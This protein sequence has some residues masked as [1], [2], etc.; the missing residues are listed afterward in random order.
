MEYEGK[1]I[2]VLGLGIEG[3]DVVGFLLGRGAKITLFDRKEEG[4]IDFTGIEK[5]KL[6]IVTGENYLSG[7]LLG[8]DLIVRSPGVYRFNTE[9]VAAEK[10]GVPITSSIKIFFDECPGKIIGVTGTKGK[11]TTSTLIHDILKSDGRDVYLS[12]NI[13]KPYLELLPKLTKDS[14]VVMEM[15][16]FQLIDADVSPHIAVVLNITEDHMDWHVDREE[17]LNAK[18]NIARFQ[19]PS[20]YAVI[21]EEY[22]ESSSFRDLTK[23]KA[24][25]F[26]KTL[27][28]DKYKEGLLLRGEHNLENIAAAITVAKILKVDEEK[29]LKTLRNFKG[30]EHR[31]ELVGE[32]NGR[33]FY[34]DS[35]STGPQPAIAAIRSFSEPETII[36]GGSD[37][38][39]DFESLWGE[40]NTRDNVKN[41]ILIGD[42]G[43]K[44]GKGITNKNIISLG[45]ASMDQIV[46]KSFEV[47]PSGGVVVFS[48]A[49]AS[50]DM[51]KNY[52]D[53]GNQ[54]KKAVQSL[55]EEK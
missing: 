21:N 30:L 13:G 4:G 17:Y 52:K 49:A 3:R 9:L 43:E 36:L 31:L 2:A 50:F 10:A 28:E 20:D 7:G 26:S 55:R 23:G 15:S 38:G 27:L 48:P 47:T 24:V 18:K 51:F 54:F 14:L 32:V 33:T 34:N 11:G 5:E 12:G 25:P 46:S 45:R 41:I 6:E 53:R 44:I 16:S 35:F 22:P 19:T 29:I 39:L 8:F 42:I 40:I 37:K 1:K